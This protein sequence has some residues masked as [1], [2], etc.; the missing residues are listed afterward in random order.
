MKTLPLYFTTLGSLALATVIYVASTGSPDPTETPLNKSLTSQ[1][2]PQKSTLAT[3]ASTTSKTPQKKNALERLNERINFTS[4][5]PLNIGTERFTI[6]TETQITTLRNFPYHSKATLTLKGKNLQGKVIANT[7]NAVDNQWIFAIALDD[8]EGAILTLQ[9]HPAGDIRGTIQNITGSIAYTIDADQ[10]GQNLSIQRANINDLICGTPTNLGIAGTHALPTTEQINADQSP[11]AP[12]ADEVNSTPALGL[13][14]S[15]G[16][17]RVLYLDFDGETVSGTSWNTNSND[18][19]T[20]QLTSSRFDSDSNVRQIFRHMAEDFKPFDINVTTDRSVY[21]AATSSQRMMVI[22][23]DYSSWYGTAGGV[24]LLNSFGGANYCC[25]AFTNNLNNA[26]NSAVVASHEAGHTLGLSHD[27]T[28]DDEYYDGHGSG[29]NSWGPIMGAPY[30]KRIQT[31]DNG[32]YPDANQLQNDFNI[33]SDKLPS[34]PDDASG[35]AALPFNATDT[36]ATLRHFNITSGN[37]PEASDTFA[38]STRGGDINLSVSPTVSV[39]NET[40]GSNLDLAITIKNQSGN[41]VAQDLG[42]G[43]INAS[44]QTTL[45]AGN[46]TLIIETT[47]VPFTFND[48]FTIGGY[49][50]YGQTGTYF[51]SGTIPEVSGIIGDTFEIIASTN[52][53]SIARTFNISSNN[54]NSVN[55]SIST[56]A[57]WLTASPS[58]GTLSSEETEITLT[59]KTENLN[60]GTHTA[61]ITVNNTDLGKINTLSFTL[62]FNA[63]VKNEILVLDDSGPANIYPS[64]LNVTGYSGRITDISV[65]LDGLSHTYSSDI[66]ALLVSPS[67]EQ[68]QLINKTGGGGNISNLSLTFNESGNA[69][70]SNLSSSGSGTYLPDTKAASTDLNSPAPPRPY[71]TKLSNLYGK[72]PNGDWKLYLLDDAPQD[73]GS[74]QSWALFIETEEITLEATS[75]AIS[76]APSNTISFNCTP[77]VTYLLE[78]SNDMLSW[79]TLETITPASTSAAVTFTP[80]SL[81]NQFF[82]IREE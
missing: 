82:R 63:I 12:L 34:R 52:S 30:G 40:S 53:P 1:L 16:S 27:G 65:R 68:I 76:A 71:L 17:A 45:P 13:Q 4:T 8:M 6:E 47:E 23:T 79:D 74:L 20:L 81:P 18:G 21:N 38:F 64:T 67:G 10:N 73:S 61:T 44:I 36:V 9:K 72:S 11:D 54:E 70:P 80:P 37:T 78:A 22:F 33:I 28:S 43:S 60:A 48:E 56:D 26:A 15:P 46:Y 50:K 69:F 58:S 5:D 2:S 62:N 55:Y 77:G 29:Y 3:P 41:I 75:Y 14:S 19:D 42:S 66:R 7:R 32:T 24:A 57:S 59:A 25:F 31:W 49:T 39:D 35:T 51:I